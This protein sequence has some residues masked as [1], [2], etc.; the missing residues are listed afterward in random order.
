MKTRMLSLLV[1][2]LLAKTSG[3]AQTINWARLQP[4]E[5]NLLH[6][7]IGFEYSFAYGLGYARQLKTKMPALLTVEISQPAGE[8]L[9][10]DFKARIGGQ[11]RLVRMNNI[12][13][14]VKVQGVFRRYQN[15]YVRMLNFGSDMS[16]TA[17][18]FGKRWFAS[19]E[20]GFDK[21][22]VTHFKHSDLL[23]ADFPGIRDGWYK[24]ATGGNLYFGLHTGLSLRKTDIA[25]RVGRVIQQ[26]FKTNPTI[27]FYCALSVARKF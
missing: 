27:P 12:Q 5:K 16:A 13:V 10:D 25:L 7:Q 4:E 18:Y 20:I 11:V 3:L 1:C 15:D 22:I 9:F 17:G 8:N 14:S 26:D 2:L 6:A 24:P 19:G 23:R 21:A